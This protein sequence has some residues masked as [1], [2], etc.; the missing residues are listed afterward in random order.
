MKN[1]K[2]GIIGATGMV[3]QRLLT[4][5]EGHPWFSVEVLAASSK[6]AGKSFEEAV[7]GRWAMAKPIP[8]KIKCM[9]VYDAEKDA[10]FIA[11]SVD[12]VFCAI[13]M[14]KAATKALE[15]KYA[16]LECP[17]MSNNSANRGVFDVPMIIPEINP[18]H[19]EVVSAQ[20]KRLGTK[21]GFI[22]VKSNCSI[23]SYVPA[24]HPLMKFGV[25]NVLTCTYQA[26]SGAGKNFERWPEMVDNLIPYIGGEEEKSENEPLKIWGKIEDGKI[27]SASSPA[28]TTQCLRVP[29]SDG[30][31]AAVFVSFDKKPT[32]DEIKKAWAEY[33]GEPQ[34]LELPSAPKQFLT[35]FEE[36]DRPQAK[37]DR[38]LENGMGISI[39]RLRADS[40][41]DYKFV[42]LSHN[43][44]R[45]AAGGNI[46]MAELYA[47][48]GYFDR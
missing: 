7:F 1:Y 4:L 20:K 10:E 34:I 45:G 43:T 13:N 2:V 30:H 39:G 25:K 17:V 38:D 18:E 15:E 44:I 5:L 40:Q 12:F 28:I 23:Q 16:K 41:Y 24:L 14:D 35:Y 22:S 37:L 46:L 42:S 32:I 11:S 26:I 8:E 21:R 9:K 27:I 19:M 33:R 3:G 48:K 6:S 31:T 36:P 47:A 29:V